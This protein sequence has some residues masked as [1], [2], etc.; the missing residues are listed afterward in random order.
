MIIILGNGQI[1][2]ALQSHIKFN[3][4][5]DKGEWNNLPQTQINILHICFPYSEVFNLLVN[6]AITVFNPKT[7][8]IHSTVPPG[9]SKKHNALYSP[10]MGRHE[11]DFKKDIQRY[12]KFC[13]G[14]EDDF[15]NFMQ[16][17]KLNTVYTGTNTD[18]LEFA[19]IM[20]TGYMYWNLI[21]EK[22]IHK[23]CTKRGYDFDFVYTKW[24][25]NYNNGVKEEWKRPIYT[26]D[27]N[28]I[29]GGHCL[30]NNIYLDDNFVN[31][32]LKQWQETKGELT[33]YRY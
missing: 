25:R 13:A 14:T 4:I 21:Y 32:L 24:N 23:E 12:N 33:L 6:E 11:N 16:N 10:V 18:Q 29:P 3:H 26:H 9:T 30:N 27:D 15:H 22:I 2:Q 8:V 20:S 5:Y 1:S 19:K 28:P 17:S 31:Q 7:I